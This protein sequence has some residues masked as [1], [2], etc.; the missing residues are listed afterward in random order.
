MKSEYLFTQ[1]QMPFGERAKLGE[2]YINAQGIEM[3]VTKITRLPGN[4]DVLVE[5][6]AVDKVLANV[7][8]WGVLFENC[9]GKD[10]VQPLGIETLGV[11]AA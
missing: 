9:G 4:A 7:L 8:W 3:E 2:K 10:E 6:M 11:Q 1:F 5:F